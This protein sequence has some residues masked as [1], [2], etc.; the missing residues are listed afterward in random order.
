MNIGEAIKKIR[1]KRHISQQSLAC[2]TDVTQGYLSLV[3]K[4]EREPGFDL[5]Y[6][7][8]GVL[9]VPSQLIL[10]MAC[11]GTPRFKKFKKPL[12]S[13]TAAVDDILAEV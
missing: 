2:E 5:I 8:A 1:K 13:I 4:G 10:L 12:N 11:E 9:K 3:E 6:K 7:I